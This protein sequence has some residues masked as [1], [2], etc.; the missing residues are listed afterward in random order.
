MIKA[1]WW[2][3]EVTI[4]GFVGVDVGGIRVIFANEDGRIDVANLTD[5]DG[6]SLFTLVKPAIEI[7]PG[8]VTLKQSNDA[9][10]WVQ[11]SGKQND[12]K[13]T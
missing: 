5:N 1:K 8:S 2:R 4:L 7:V 13:R 10:E 6:S 12:K 9:P 3:G 11:K